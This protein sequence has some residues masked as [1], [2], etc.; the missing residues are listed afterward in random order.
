MHTCTS[1][2][3]QRT[4]LKTH[5]I[6]TLQSSLCAQWKDWSF[7]LTWSSSLLGALGSQ[8]N[9]PAALWSCCPHHSWW[10]PGKSLVPCSLSL[11]MNLHWSCQGQH[12]AKLLASAGIKVYTHNLAKVSIAGPAAQ[13][14]K[15][16]RTWVLSIYL[17]GLRIFLDL[18]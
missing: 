15:T 7:P 5:T 9:H 12:Y 8:G 14:A 13:H 10:S 2:H 1:T 16:A 17:R 6:P 11:D 4:V 3:T 18:L